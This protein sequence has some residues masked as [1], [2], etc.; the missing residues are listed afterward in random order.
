M[1]V[2]FIWLK[3]WAIKL[4]QMWHHVCMSYTRFY[5]NIKPQK[6]TCLAVVRLDIDAIK[7]LQQLEHRIMARRTC[8]EAVQKLIEQLQLKHET[9]KIWYIWM[10]ELCELGKVPNGALV[11]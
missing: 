9:L 7:R 5:D 8:L 1:E 6:C 2:V 3:C 10:E 4:T 11:V